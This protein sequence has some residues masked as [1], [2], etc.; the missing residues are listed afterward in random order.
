MKND[1]ARNILKP[2]KKSRS[3]NVSQNSN[4]HNN[5]INFNINFDLEFSKI[6]NR[7]DVQ[8]SKNPL[9]KILVK[10]SMKQIASNLN[11]RALRSADPRA[12]GSQGPEIRRALGSAD[13]SIKLDWVG[14]NRRRKRWITQWLRQNA[15]IEQNFWTS[16]FEWSEAGPQLGLESDHG[17]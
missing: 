6:K 1:T 16:T 4:R 3:T 8:K 12:L 5:C 2:V 17:I 9:I 13:D 7:T 11:P 14:M 10:K 15:T